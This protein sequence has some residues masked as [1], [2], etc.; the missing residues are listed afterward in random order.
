MAHDKI[1]LSEKAVPDWLDQRLPTSIK[2]NEDIFEFLKFML[3]PL[4]KRAQKMVELYNQSKP[5]NNLARKQSPNRR[6]D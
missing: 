4:T 3:N 6:L 2:T 1:T 5:P